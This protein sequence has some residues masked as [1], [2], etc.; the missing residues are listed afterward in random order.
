MELGLQVAF[1]IT[2]QYST[3]DVCFWPVAPLSFTF[4]TTLTSVLECQ[5]LPTWT[6]TQWIPKAQFLSSDR[7]V[8][9]SYQRFVFQTVWEMMW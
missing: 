1:C 3:T 2:K 7:G 4:A 6:L 9:I 5:D 8:S